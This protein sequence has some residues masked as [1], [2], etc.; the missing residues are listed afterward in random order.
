MAARYVIGHPGQNIRPQSSH[1]RGASQCPQWLW[2]EGIWFR[3]MSGRGGH[4]H[5]IE[6]DHEWP[7]ED[8]IMRYDRGHL[9]RQL[10][11][12]FFILYF[13]FLENI[14]PLSTYLEPQPNQTGR[15]QICGNSRGRH[16]RRTFR[17]FYSILCPME[18]E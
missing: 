10:G 11:I 6:E 13:F 12:F 3:G 16:L 4:W 15:H 18:H 14:A 17:V 1:G 7:E 8:P 9:Y 5:I 2:S